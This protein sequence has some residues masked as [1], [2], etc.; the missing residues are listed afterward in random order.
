MSAISKNLFKEA[1][2]VLVGGVNS[3]VRSFAGVGGTPRF[4]AK[5]KGPYLWDEDGKRYIDYVG[6]WGA[7]ILGHAF[8]AVGQAVEHAAALGTSYGACHKSEIHLASLIKSA[9]PKSIDLLRFTN[10]GTEAAMTALR[11]ARAA[12]GRE[13]IV[14]F[15]GG[16]HGHHESFLVAAGSG[17]LTLGVPNSRGVPK[18]WAQTTMVLP[19]NDIG[20]IRRAFSAYG[21]KIAA[22]IVEPVA[23]NMGV[24]PPLPGFLETLRRVTKDYGSLLI[25]DE[26]ITGFRFHWGGFA[27]HYGADLVCLGKIIGGGFPVGAVGGKKAVM[28][29]L[30]PMGDVYHAGTLSGNP[31]AMAAGAAVLKALKRL[32]PYPAM[33]QKARYL[34][35]GLQQAAKAGNIALTINQ[36]GGL[37]TAFFTAK[38]VVHYKSAQATDT[39]RFSRFFNK[40]LDRGVYFPPSN[41]EACFM[42]VAHSEQDVEKTLKALSAGVAA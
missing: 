11:L 5:A 21:R 23:C 3:P 41:F 24:V 32:N 40:L 8:K 9:F 19:Y 28:E 12:A 16:Y 1:R 25:F 13:H 29:L 27:D 7:I 34:V 10:S 38:S 14:K 26:V 33:E 6:S 36:K 39:K 22:V 15:A 2:Q 37:F 17:A 35:Q 20:A 18:S 4:V 42:S 30:A 31:V